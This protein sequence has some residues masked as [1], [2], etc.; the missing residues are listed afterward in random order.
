MLEFE[1]DMRGKVLDSL[2]VHWHSWERHS[3]KGEEF[4]KLGG[5]LGTWRENFG[6][7]GVDFLR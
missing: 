7:L 5:N 6:D 1:F 2:A 4:D 3:G